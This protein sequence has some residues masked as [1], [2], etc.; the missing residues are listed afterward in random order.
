MA[1]EPAGDGPDES[2]ESG[3]PAAE[4]REEEPREPWDRGLFFEV[5]V[6]FLVALVPSVFYGLASLWLPEPGS[7]PFAYVS[8][9]AF[10]HAAGS[11]ALVLY[12]VHGSGEPWSD[13]GFPRPRVWDILL[14]PLVWGFAWAPLALVIFPVAL[15]FI[16]PV[17]QAAFDARLEL[18][19]PRPEAPWQYVLL[20]LECA[21]VGFGEEALFRAYL[22]PRCARLLRSEGWSLVL[23][24]AAFALCHAYQGPLGVLG[25]AW[26]GLVFGA[27]FLV[28]RRVWPLALAHAVNNFVFTVW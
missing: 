9:A 4:E 3:A 21:A 18:W 2:T 15:A 1:E 10:L 12:F 25:T 27:F 22:V 17:A 19:F 14:A 26:W 20:V 5:C 6:V 13:S 7:L 28:V 24:S 16:D 11:A 23:C 8:L